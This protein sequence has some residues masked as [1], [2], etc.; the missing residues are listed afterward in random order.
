M[1]LVDILVGLIIFLSFLGGLK[2]GAVKAFFSLVG[3]LIAIPLTGASY[4]LIANL[5]SFMPG[6]DWENFLGFFITLAI[7]G[8]IL[9]LIFLLPRKLIQQAWNEGAL[10]RLIGGVLNGFNSIIGLVV[11]SLVLQAYPIWEWLER[12]VTGSTVLPWLVAHLSF[13]QL[14]LPQLSQRTMPTV[15]TKLLLYL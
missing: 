6:E 12:I 5:L 1:I 2:D 9:F 4:H 13:V 10:F 7:I 14:M 11:F 8:I 15:L 3:F